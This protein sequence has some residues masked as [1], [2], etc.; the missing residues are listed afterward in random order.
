MPGRVF[1]SMNQG[2]PLLVDHDVHAGVSSAAHGRERRHR[3]T[4]GLA[5][6]RR[7]P[8]GPAG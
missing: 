5:R 6:R 4:L 3:Q 2:V 8:V 1:T 7:E